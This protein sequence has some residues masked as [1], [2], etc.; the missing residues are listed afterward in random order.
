MAEG[1]GGGELSGHW[2]HEKHGMPEEPGMSWPGGSRALGFSLPGSPTPFT[3][4]SSGTS[5]TDNHNCCLRATDRSP[6]ARPCLHRAP[7]GS[8]GATQAKDPSP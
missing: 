4:I 3:K 1:K 8:V 5:F 2:G 7:C 6:A